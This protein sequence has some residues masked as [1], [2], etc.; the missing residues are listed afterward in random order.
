VNLYLLIGLAGALLHR[1]QTARS[2][3]YVPAAQLA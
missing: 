3:A 1:Y 2:P